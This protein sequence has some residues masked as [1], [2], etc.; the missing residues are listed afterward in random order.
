LRVE[1]NK[2][3]DKLYKSI[4]ITRLDT[5][6]KILD[7][8]DT[9][10]YKGEKDE[11]LEEYSWNIFEKVAL[12]VTEYGDKKD[13]IVL[14]HFI[15]LDDFMLLARDISN[16]KAVNFQDFKG[17]KSDKYPTGY[18]SRTLTIEVWPEGNNGK[19]AY[20][21]SIASGAGVAGDKG[22]VSPEKGAPTKAIKMILTIPEARRAF[23]CAYNYFNCKQTAFLAV[24]YRNLFR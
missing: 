13:S 1:I 3:Q 19:G 6:G 21:L 16:Q 11:G 8:Q 7:V 2:Y 5:R 18:E 14:R 9:V 4:Q 20:V 17:G 22:Q 23:L 12:N 10:S 24:E 15:D